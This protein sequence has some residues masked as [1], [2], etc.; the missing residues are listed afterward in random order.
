ML[1]F[2]CQYFTDPYE[3]SG[4]NVEVALDLFNYTTNVDLNRAAGI[5]ASALASKTDL[6]SIKSNINDLDEDELKTTK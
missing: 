4:W 1:T 2:S 3:R 5:D 6:A